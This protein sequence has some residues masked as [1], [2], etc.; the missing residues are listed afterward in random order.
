MIFLTDDAAARLAA[1]SIGYHAHGTMGILIRSIRRHQRKK[2]EVLSILKNLPT[3]SSL[4]I[5]PSLLQ[6]IID[7]V[8]KHSLG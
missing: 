5:K 3:R 2:E 1:A 7:R 6:E 8:E 4:F